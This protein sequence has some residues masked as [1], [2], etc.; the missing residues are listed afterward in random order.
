M[1]GSLPKHY[2]DILKIRKEDQEPWMIA[3]KEEIK[4]LH[5]RK[6]WNLIDLP[7]GRQIIKGR[8]VYAMKSKSRKKAQSVAKGFT[9]VFRIDYE[10]TFSPVAQFE[11]LQLLLSLAA[12]HD[13]E[14]EALDVKTAFL[15][16]E[17]KEEGKEF[18]VCRLQK[19]I[20]GLKQAALQWNKQ[21][22]KSLL[23]MDFT[24][25]LSD[26]GI[27]FKIIGQ[28]III[29]LVYVDNALFMGSN[30]TQVLT[31][32]KQFIK[33]WESRDLGEAKEYL[34]MKIMRNHK[35]QTITL[36]QTCYVEKVIKQFGQENCKPVSVPLPTRYNPRSNSDKEANATL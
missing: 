3:M 2:K 25:S 33:R 5:E 4:S 15:F 36:D 20:Y 6:V 27:H 22:H 23:E 14:L 28:E 7:K 16:G 17:L 24:H 10:N 18:K 19:A 12:L 8:W 1:L 13:W 29:L 31:H 21:L 32:K 9:Q 34:G 35:K 30:K 26:P 11:T